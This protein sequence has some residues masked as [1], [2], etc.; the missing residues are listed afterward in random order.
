MKGA[1]GFHKMG[2]RQTASFERQACTNRCI[3]RSVSLPPPSPNFPLG[4][5][6]DHAALDVATLQRQSLTGEANHNH[7]M[8]SLFISCTPAFTQTK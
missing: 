2:D 6:T 4:D 7:S 3:G 5:S 8:C 1:R